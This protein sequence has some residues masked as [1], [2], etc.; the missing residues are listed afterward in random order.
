[1]QN[2]NNGIVLTINSVIMLCQTDY[3]MQ[4][5]YNVSHMGMTR[6]LE[7]SGNSES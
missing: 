7:F 5:F 1:M 6:C 3:N 4:S 2:G